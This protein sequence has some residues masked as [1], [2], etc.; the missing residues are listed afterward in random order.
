MANEPDKINNKICLKI[1]MERI[2]RGWSQEQLGEYSDI[3]KTSIGAI[4]RGQSTP[5]T[6]TLAKIATAFN[7]TVSELTDISKVDLS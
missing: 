4:E 2:K 6:L 7:M 3:S 5:S 1:K